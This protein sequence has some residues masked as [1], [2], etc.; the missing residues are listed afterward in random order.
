M[1]Y[2]LS[3]S[4]IQKKHSQVLQKA[5]KFGHTLIYS[6]YNEQFKNLSFEEINADKAKIRFR[7]KKEAILE[8]C[9][10]S[11]PEKGIQKTT[12]S[13]Y[14]NARCGFL[15]CGRKQ[16]SQKFQGRTFSLE[17]LKKMSNSKKGQ[18]QQKPSRKES[19]I[20]KER[21]A[22]WRQAVQENWN[23][24]CA[25]PLVKS[26]RFN[27]HHLYSKKVFPSLK[28]DP[29]NGVLLD[30]KIHQYFQ[31]TVGS[32]NIV[33]ADHFLEFLQKLIDSESFRE[34][35]FQKAIPRHKYPTYEQQIS[36]ILSFSNDVPSSGGQK[37][38]C[39][40]TNTYYDIENIWNQTHDRIQNFSFFKID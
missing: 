10:E 1:V 33:T 30:E 25:I 27:V 38:K 40:E 18:A 9:C 14:L 7:S 4:K 19:A 3:I 32:L 16:V 5:Q 21:S 24:L 2:H 22:K 37:D 35:V 11:H 36:N 26:K 12:V 29:E 34:D 6:E 39:S 13:K 31:N 15:C 28:Y 23:F 8:L 20:E 17:T